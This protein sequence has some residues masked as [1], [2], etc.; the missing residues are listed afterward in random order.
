MDHIDLIPIL[1]YID[2]LG[3]ATLITV[4]GKLLLLGNTKPVDTDA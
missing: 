3:D 4:E 1:Q 2:Q